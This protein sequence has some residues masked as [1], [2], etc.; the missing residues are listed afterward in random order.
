MYFR[1]IFYFWPDFVVK[2]IKNPLA[3]CKFLFIRINEG[4]IRINVSAKISEELSLSFKELNV[5]KMN[6]QTSESETVNLSIDVSAVST[7]KSRKIN[8]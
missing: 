3:S 4:K 1:S 8:P 6:I 5:Q 7:E 2:K